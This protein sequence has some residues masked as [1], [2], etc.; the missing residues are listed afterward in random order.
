M[1]EIFKIG[2]LKVS[3]PPDIQLEEIEFMS[4][5]LFSYIQSVRTKDSRPPISVRLE[6]KAEEKE[7]DDV[8][9]S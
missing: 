9:V 5:I 4:I 1:V 8:G 6:K 7:R 2:R 3:F